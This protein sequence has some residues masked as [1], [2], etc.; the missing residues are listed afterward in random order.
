MYFLDIKREFE[1][2]FGPVDKRKCES[3]WSGADKPGLNDES[4]G[5]KPNAFML[6]V[7]DM[8]TFPGSQTNHLFATIRIK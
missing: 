4:L 3:N 6:L 8:L 7:S 1:A 2:N 5:Q